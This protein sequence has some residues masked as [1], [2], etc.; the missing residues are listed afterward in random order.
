MSDPS[1]EGPKNK[2]SNDAVEDAE[3]VEPD[4][5]QASTS[6]S[7]S[8]ND[9]A[10]DQVTSDTGPDD[11]PGV[12][13]APTPE[14]A[15]A[16]ESEDTKAAEAD[17][18]EPNQPDVPEKAAEPEVVQQSETEDAQSSGFASTALKYVV[19]A[20]VVFALMLAFVPWLLTKLPLSVS[21]SLM[22]AQMV[23]ESRFSDVEDRFAAIEAQLAGDQSA[24]II[25]ALEARIAELQAR[26]EASEQEAIEARTAAEEAAR[27][28]E[29][30][31][32]SEGVVATAGAAA[33]RAASAADTA[34]TAATE[35]GRV[36]SSAMRDAASLARRMTGFEAQLAAVS[37][38]LNTLGVNLAATPGP[39]DGTTSN[40]AAAAYAALKTRIDDLIAQINTAD[41]LTGD[42][43][44]ALATQDDLRSARTALTANLEAALA[45]MPLGEEI[46]TKADIQAIV[47]RLDAVAAEA[48]ALEARATAAETAAAE[49]QGQVGVAIK[50]AELDAAV[51]TMMT[52]LEHGRPFAASLGK[53]V[54]LSGAEAPAALSDVAATGTA[55][56]DELLAS[57]GGAYQLAV[58]ADIREQS[59]G[60]MFGNATARLR[61][62]A[63]GRPK[64]A[65]E[66]TTVEAVL[67][68]VEAALRD[69]ELDL[70]LTETSG[71][72]DQ[73]QSAMGDWLD[74]LETRAAAISAAG[75]YTAGIGTNQG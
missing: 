61:S 57:F 69:G 48:A 25:A 59:D 54:E 73:V 12:E 30:A 23:T 27:A 74:S 71:L 15:E 62:I 29:S 66:G 26:V 21:E 49:A 13:E 44:V 22:P 55:T 19:G 16:A 4:G 70:A 56:T 6:E 65:Q 10:P 7:L 18:A 28:A 46:A 33:D 34:T 24:E 72:S 35:A 64:G 38:E 51:A 43:A 50:R 3:I 41:Y 32:V 36:A 14:E 75:D 1:T 52:R 8:A 53:V 37:D 45:R 68:R 40:E 47:A 42:D 63:S 11:K 58:A 2:T 20:V 67:S 31:G 17:A 60:G 39:E 5:S 9:E